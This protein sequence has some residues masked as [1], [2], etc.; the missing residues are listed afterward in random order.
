MSDG[1]WRL[2]L[3]LMGWVALLLGAT[4]VV[5]G[6]LPDPLPVG[7]YRIAAE[8]HVLLDTATGVL[9]RPGALQ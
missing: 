3:V 4:L 5:Q 2:N 7:R 6:F 1:A 9:T 8:G